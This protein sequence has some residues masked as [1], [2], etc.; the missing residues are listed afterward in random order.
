MCKSGVIQTP[1][2]IVEKLDQEVSR[3]VAGLEGIE[4][5]KSH[6]NANYPK[7]DNTQ[8]ILIA[9][10]DRSMRVA[11]MNILDA[12]G[13]QLFEV[14][15]GH[16][17]VNFCKNNMP[18]LVLLDAVMP[19]MSGLEACKKIRQIDQSSHVPILIVTALDDEESVE[20]AFRVGATDYLSKPVH[21][22]VLRQR[23]ARLLHASKVEKHVQQLAY[24]DSLTG[25]PNRTTF[26]S[27]LMSMLAKTSKTKKIAILFL[28]LNR[29]KLVNDTLGH[30][31]GDLL[32]KAVADRM[33]RCV[34]SGDMVARL[35]GDEFAVVIDRVKSQDSLSRIANTTCETLDKPFSFA[36]K[37]IFVSTSIGIAIFPDDGT[38]MD[39]LMKHADAAMFRAKDFGRNYMFYGEHGGECY[40]KD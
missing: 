26:S 11:L 25:L 7:K 34:H 23:I 35:G 14:T 32:L 30:S 21:F 12:D 27:Q 37:E 4:S 31:V 16:Q 22:S 18:D 9:D 5:Q 13:Y 38:D 19:E 40:S 24:T 33:R 10:D 8:T 29:F 36:G 17:A 20:H 2:E 6:E 15:D 1:D 39:S 3:V 28:D